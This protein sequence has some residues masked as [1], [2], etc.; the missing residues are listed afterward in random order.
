M[1]KETVDKIS[2]QNLREKRV[3]ERIPNNT[4]QIMQ[5]VKQ[6]NNQ[7]VFKLLNDYQ[8]KNSKMKIGLE[9]FKEEIYFHV[10]DE[11]ECKPQIGLQKVNEFVVNSNPQDPSCLHVSEETMKDLKPLCVDFR[12]T[13]ADVDTQLD[14]AY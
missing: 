1:L 13:R 14:D 3:G 2:F 6:D 8:R 7:E 4:E 12:G 9:D 5:T 11:P 10:Y